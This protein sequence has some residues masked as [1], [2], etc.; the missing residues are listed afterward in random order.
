MLKKLYYWLHRKTSQASER[1]ECS[2]G[3]WQ[4]LVR[5]NAQ[6]LIFANIGSVLEAGCGEGLFISQVAQKYP[7]I[8]IVGVD[9]RKEILLKAQRRIKGMNNVNLVQGDSCAL[10]FED[11]SFEVIVCINVS[12]SLTSEEFLYRALSEL[13][14][15]CKSGGSIIFDIRNSLNPLLRLKYSLAKYYDETIKGSPLRTYSPDK[16]TTYLERNGLKIVNRL[17]VC[18]PKNR[19]TP[20]IIFEV[21]KI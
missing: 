12:L 5:R 4:D 10:P 14:R 20:I 1:G 8:I 6:K 7:K 17:N 18:F 13:S 2:S 16:V 9:I 21:K 3:Y 11:N 19:F 15:V